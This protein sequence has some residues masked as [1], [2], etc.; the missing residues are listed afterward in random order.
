VDGAV[1]AAKQSPT[2]PPESFGRVI[3]LNCR[4]E[5]LS[6]LRYHGA[7]ARH[8]KPRDQKVIVFN[9]RGGPRD[10]EIA[11]SDQPVDFVNEALTC[12][13]VSRQGTIGRRILSKPPSETGPMGRQYYL[14]VDLRDT[15]DEIVVTCEYCE[16]G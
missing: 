7:M 2:M 6:K 13:A 10:G 8:T 3:R 14:V 4:K 16:N 11:R 15:A 1:S 5:V 12:W 9:F